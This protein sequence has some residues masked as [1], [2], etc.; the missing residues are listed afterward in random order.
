MSKPTRYYDHYL[1]PWI[2]L[3]FCSKRFLQKLKNLVKVTIFYI[4]LRKP[5]ILCVDL[6][7]N[8]RHYVVITNSII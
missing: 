4:F 5:F 3:K 1:I 8:D 2:I 7:S 6:L